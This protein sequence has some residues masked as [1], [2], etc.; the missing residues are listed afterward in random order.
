MPQN[1]GK[2]TFYMNTYILDTNLFFNMEPG[3]NLG[4]TTKDV[5]IQATTL[6]KAQKNAT[7]IMSPR[8]VDELKSF[9]EQELP[10]Y[11]EDFLIHIEIRSPDPSKVQFSAAVFY[12]L[13][14]DV[15][16]RNYK[17]LRAAEDEI[18][19]AASQMMGKEVLPK[20]AFEMTVGHSIQ[21]FRTRYRNATRT[22][23]I[24]SL[25]DL[26]IIML[27]R[28]L[29]GYIVTTDAGVLEWGRTF[30]VKE[31]PAELFAKHLER[32]AQELG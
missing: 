22:G 28:E 2:H 18:R 5:L 30:G 29:D 1:T 25:A 6:M 23:F 16:E 9:F 21:S 10:T 32:D 3:L 11:V 8:I 12:A 24:D 14:D 19:K 31:L 4:K 20:Q 26:D 13:I 7:F 15:R 17:G 27:A